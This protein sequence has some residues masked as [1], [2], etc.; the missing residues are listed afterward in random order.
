VQPR[1]PEIAAVGKADERETLLD[2]L[3]A[4]PQLIGERPGQT[5]I[6][7]KN[8]FGREFEQELAELDIQLLRPT[9]KTPQGL[10]CQTG[11]RGQVGSGFREGRL[12]LPSGWAGAGR[13]R[14]L[15]WVTGSW[16]CGLRGLGAV[17]PCGCFVVFVAGLDASVQD[18]DQAAGDPAQRVVVAGVMRSQLVVV[19]AGPG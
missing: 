7:D 6:G 14:W 4:E 13:L 2:L 18:A 8:Y 3:G 9:R 17:G 19:G 5:L 1:P 15:V 10:T 11:V 12:T 16:L